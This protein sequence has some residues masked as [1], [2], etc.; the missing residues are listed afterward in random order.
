M[1]YE[2]GIFKVEAINNL[3]IPHNSKT[4]SIYK[5]QII[6]EKTRMYYTNC[7]KANH[8][9]ETC[10]VKRKERSIPTFFEVTTQQIKVQ[11]LV[12]YSCHICREIGYKIRLSSVQ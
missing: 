11:R 6:M 5:P 10:R 8:N 4:I 1:V 3:L 12:K 7:H 9:D 2:K